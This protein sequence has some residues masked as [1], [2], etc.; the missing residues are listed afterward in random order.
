MAAAPSLRKSLLN[1]SG[2]ETYKCI[3]VSNQKGTKLNEM[4]Q[5][6]RH[7]HFS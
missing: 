1:V 5:E 4:I 7:L 6:Q 3:K 2:C